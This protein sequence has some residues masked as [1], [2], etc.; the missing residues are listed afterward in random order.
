MSFLIASLLCF[1]L[2]GPCSYAILLLCLDAE[3]SN[4]ASKPLI[5]WTLFHRLVRCST[6]CRCSFG[7]SR[8]VAVTRLSLM[9]AHKCQAF[10]SSSFL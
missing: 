1:S 5:S 9:V 6:L 4:V 8:E 10:T 3:A 2:N 7:R